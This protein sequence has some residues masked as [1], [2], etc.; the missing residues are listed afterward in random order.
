MYNFC[1]IMVA[2]VPETLS[3]FGSGL[4]LLVQVIILLDFTHSWNDAWVEK[5]ERKWLVQSNSLS[6]PFAAFVCSGM[7]STFL[8]LL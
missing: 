4:F 2:P 5:D 6:A 3:K 1:V 7:T 8:S